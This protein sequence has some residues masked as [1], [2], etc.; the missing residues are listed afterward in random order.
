[1]GSRAS[2]EQAVDYQDGA[3]EARVAWPRWVVGLPYLLPPSGRPIGEENVTDVGKLQPDGS[4][5]RVT[6]GVVKG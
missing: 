4:R 3:S 1:M 5:L 6:G 2:A